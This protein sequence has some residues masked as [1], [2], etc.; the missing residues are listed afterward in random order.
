[1][2][3]PSTSIAKKK[4]LFYVRTLSDMRALF[5]HSFSSAW[6]RFVRS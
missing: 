1:M 3:L 4:V 5:F 2:I 6:T